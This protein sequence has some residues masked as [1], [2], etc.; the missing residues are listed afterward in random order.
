MFGNSAHLACLAAHNTEIHILFPSEV[1]FGH[2][3]T[4]KGSKLH[5]STQKP[6]P[7]LQRLLVCPDQ[8]PSGEGRIRWLFYFVAVFLKFID[9]NGNR[10]A[11][12]VKEPLTT[13]DVSNKFLKPITSEKASQSYCE[14]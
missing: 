3:S 11:F 13:T 10:D 14:S 7:F 8:F 5:L 12:F 9:N 6:I 4:P 1:E 2:L